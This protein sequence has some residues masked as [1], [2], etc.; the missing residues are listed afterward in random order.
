MNQASARVFSGAEAVRD[1]PAPSDS[2]DDT[3]T[4]E[5]PAVGQGDL[6]TAFPADPDEEITPDLIIEALLFSSETPLTA[7]RL[8]ALLGSGNAREIR[9]HIDALNQRYEQQ[10]TAF[11]VINIAGGYQMMTRPVFAT[12]VG[13]L[14]ESKQ[15]NRLSP[16]ALETLAVVAYKQPVVRAEIEALR[17]VSAGEML[18][19]LRELGLIKIV[20]RAE[21]VGR[22]MLYGTTRRF[23]EVFGLS[24]LEDLPAVGELQASLDQR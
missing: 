8:V 23:L 13:R 9:K 3:G 4:A 7:P 2:P 22:P 14:R 17:G 1:E 11:R 19:R 6:W 24:G 5:A 15:D 10:K 21:D 16:A 20:G 18:N 12:W